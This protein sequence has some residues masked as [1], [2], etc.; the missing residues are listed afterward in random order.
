MISALRASTAARRSVTV[1]FRGITG[2]IHLCPAS[3]AILKIGM[4][5]GRQGICD[6]LK[7]VPKFGDRITAGADTVRRAGLSHKCMCS[8]IRTG[9]AAPCSVTVV[10][11]RI[12][13][14]INPVTA[15]CTVFEICMRVR[16]IRILC[17]AYCMSVRRSGS[18]TRAYALRDAVSSQIGSEP[19]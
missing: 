9:S 8:A 12:A 15:V 17:T 1:V 11:D 6:T 5:V 2:G 4:W 3:G 10:L 14:D 16:C 19:H 7:C 18:T 13:A